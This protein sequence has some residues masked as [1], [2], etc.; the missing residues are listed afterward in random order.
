MYV[1]FFTQV[2]D[3]SEEKNAHD[4]SQRETVN[5]LDEDEVVLYW[6]ESNSWKYIRDLASATTDED[7]EVLVYYRSVHSL[8]LYYVLFL[9]ANMLLL[10]QK[11]V[12]LM[13]C[14]LK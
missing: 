12:L 13:A 11:S 9:T 10:H 7:K 4:E 3:E 14:L 1:K 2:E 8:L 6:N 5:L